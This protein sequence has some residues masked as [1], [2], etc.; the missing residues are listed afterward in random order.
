[1]RN[2]LV[3]VAMVLLA[4]ALARGW[5]CEA[6]D[7][8]AHLALDAMTPRAREAARA[9]LV[10]NPI[11]GKLRRF[12]TRRSKDPFVDASSWADDLR[13]HRPDTGPWHYLNVP[14]DVRPDESFAGFCPSRGCVTR[15][16]R[17][18]MDRLR[19]P[20][21]EVQ[22]ADALR[23][24]VHFVADLHQPLHVA[25][26]GDRGGNCVAVSWFG[27]RP[28]WAASKLE[29]NLHSVWDGRLVRRLLERERLTPYH[30]SKR[31]RDRHADRIP[32]WRDAPADVDAWAREAHRVGVEIAYGAL[33]VPIPRARRGA[34][35]DCRESGV[36]D[37]ML[38]LDLRIDEAYVA[39]ALPVLEAQLAKAGARLAGIVN[40]AWP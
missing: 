3:G 22:R 13:E 23:F 10:A 16:V 12:C 25:D 34:A 9:L 26:N 5:G 33:A 6:H 17:S 1:M 31:L 39:R 19:S 4:P 11:D 38:A 21:S 35:P 30:W 15:V 14:L 28:R 40:A 7:A 24:L 36:G 18:E 29:P 8:V 32:A 27:D 37:R 20:R 2:V